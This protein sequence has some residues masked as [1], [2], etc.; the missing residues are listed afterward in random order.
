MLC[1]QLWTDPAHLD[2]CCGQKP[3]AVHVTQVQQMDFISKNFVYRT[4]PLGEAVKRCASTQHQD[5]FTSSSEMYVI[6]SC[7]RR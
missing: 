4:L 5:F 6:M 3:V 7:A 2:K 1:P